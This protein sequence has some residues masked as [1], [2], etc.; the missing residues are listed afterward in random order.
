MYFV[1]DKA[2]PVVSMRGRASRTGRARMTGAYS[3]SPLYAEGHIYFQ[4]ETGLTTVITPGKTFNKVAEN[5]LDG[6][7]FASIATVGK[8]IFLRTDT[9]L[10]RIE[11]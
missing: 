9:H 5:Q 2:S 4:N 6:R 1:S 8:A 10:Y 7:T 11:N 3:A